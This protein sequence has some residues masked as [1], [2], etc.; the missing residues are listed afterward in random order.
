MFSNGP[1]C[2]LVLFMF[3]ALQR[4]SGFV[5][6][7]F[8]RNKILW[9]VHRR[10]LF[11]ALKP[12]ESYRILKS[13]AGC[14]FC[15]SSLKSTSRR[16]RS[17][18][19]AR[20]LSSSSQDNLAEPS[21]SIDSAQNVILCGLNPNQVQAVTQPCSSISRVIAG[22]GSGKTRV[23]TSRIAWL[24]Q[25]DDQARILAVTFTRKAASEMQERVV[26][27]LLL[28][29][30][31]NCGTSAILEGSENGAN[32]SPAGLNR[33][34][35]GTFH[36]ICAKI[37]RWN[38][39]VLRSLPSVQHDLS[40]SS[41]ATSLDGAFNIV[42]QA[43]QIRIVKEALAEF[44]IDLKRY[45][46]VKPLQIVT[47]IGR[48]KA[49][50]AHG[51]NPFDYDKKSKM[52]QQ[53]R[54]IVKTI[55]YSCRDKLLSANSLDF[56]DLI[57]LAREL[58]MTNDRVREVLQRRWTHVLIDEFQDTSI[59][60]LDLVKLLTSS[61]LFVVGDGDQSIYSW[62]G[63]EAESL[64]AFDSEFHEFHSDGVSTIFLMENYRYA[65]TFAICS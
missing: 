58:L 12:S 51:K 10:A 28:M 3:L 38:G 31:E 52:K 11:R 14:R 23:L 47:D 21:P 50:L 7:S 13:L 53:V 39:D 56:D 1:Y 33:V 41:N 18:Q 54:E 26:K 48:C 44:D 55:Y 30:E 29:Q 36:S 22:P 15:C 46:D 43:E 17:Q 57:L 63:A 25:Q 49:L 27:L 65:I 19:S 5:C 37:L 45:R 64:S 24:L 16:K 32:K 4:I 40:K 2:I 8:G 59:T 20:Y 60:Q 62:R 9:P 34:T 42:D 61:S 35:L 6:N